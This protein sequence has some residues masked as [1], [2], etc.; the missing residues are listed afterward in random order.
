LNWNGYGGY[1]KTESFVYELTK[2]FAPY[3]RIVLYKTDFVFLPFLAGLNGH[4]LVMNE[5]QYAEA[6]EI[7]R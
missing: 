1:G 6:Q 2:K 4:Y 7:L 5:Q 3:I